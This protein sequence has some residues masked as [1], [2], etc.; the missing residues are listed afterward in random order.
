M[1]TLRIAYRVWQVYW[2]HLGVFFVTLFLMLAINATGAFPRD[3]VRALNLAPF[4]DN[5][6]PNLIGL[7]TLTYVPNYFDILPMYLVILALIPVTMALARVDPR[8]ALL[9][10]VSALGGGGGRTEPARGPLVQQRVG[11][12]MVLQ[13]LRLAAGVLHRLR[14]DG[15]LAAPRRPSVA[16]SWRWRS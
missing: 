16:G 13:P 2:V 11:P 1:G 5:T 9:L 6:G 8:L 14:A 7:M 12:D 15:G 10:C 4:L 3:E